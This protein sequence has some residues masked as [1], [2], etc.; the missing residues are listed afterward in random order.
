MGKTKSLDGSKPAPLGVSLLL[1]LSLTVFCSTAFVPPTCSA[2]KQQ[3][4]SGDKASLAAME[5]K[6]FFKTYAE[7]EQEARLARIEKKVFG[8]AAQGGFQERLARVMEVVKPAAESAPATTGSAAP[9]PSNPQPNY[10]EEQEN[11]MERARLALQAEKEE[12][13][14][15][16]LSEGVEYWRGKHGREA[17]DRF[18][19][20]L[21]L[22]PN[23]AEAHF[24]MGIIYESSGNFVEA[25][26]S[27]KRA[28]EERPDNRDYR[29]AVAAVEKKLLAKQKV[30]DKQGELRILAEDASAAYKRGEYISA[31]ELYKQ[32]DAKA[33]NQALVK[34]NIGTLYLAI[35]NPFTALEY[36]QQARKL[37]PDEPRYVTACE[38]LGKNIQN[39]EAERTQAEQAWAQAESGNNAPQDGKKKHKD[40]Q[41]QQQQMP[42]QNQGNFNQPVST[43]G[44]QDPMAS[45]GIIGRSSKDGVTV[46]AVGIASRA[47]KVG[48]LKGDIIKAVDGTVVKSTGDLNNLLARKGGASVQLMVQ[49]GT[50]LGQINL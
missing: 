45:Y 36:Y 16:L 42:Q 41:P 5:Q 14:S 10:E 13:V 26:V 25:S 1:A 30:D 19:Q 39:A 31:L 6:L 12:K 18:E 8:D 21:K 7:E 29:D 23:N 24:S 9:P 32:L 47:S 49:R 40:K 43:N 27:Y 34:Y 15:K 22:D 33:P 3:A 37:K 17:I 2:T 48:L 44:G 46:T 38:Q 20:V 28:S 50:Q 11:A 35:K 4:E